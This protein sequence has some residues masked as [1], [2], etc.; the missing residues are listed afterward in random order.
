MQ[1][2][3]LTNEGS[4]HRTLRQSLGGLIWSGRFLSLLLLY[5][6]KR[7]HAKRLLLFLL[8]FIMKGFY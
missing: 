5:Y 7:Y 2:A 6:V 8:L 3:T 4:E 1:G